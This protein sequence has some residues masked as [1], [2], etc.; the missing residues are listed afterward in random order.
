[1]VGFIFGIIVALI[2]LGVGIYFALCKRIETSEE[3]VLNENGERM[4]SP[5]GGYRTETKKTVIKPFAK[6]TPTS[7]APIRPGA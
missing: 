1:M 7:R 4:R 2:G 3:Y 6:F 5:Y